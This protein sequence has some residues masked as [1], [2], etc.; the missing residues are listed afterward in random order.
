M[1]F[2]SVQPGRSNVRLPQTRKTSDRQKGGCHPRC[3]PGLQNTFLMWRCPLFAGLLLSA[4]LTGPAGPQS[5]PA[6]E[7]ALR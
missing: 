1:V 4:L 7:P 3:T 5:F 6:N 2:S